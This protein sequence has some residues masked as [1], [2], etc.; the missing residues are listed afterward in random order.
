MYALFSV[1]FYKYFKYLVSAIIFF[2]LL[3][4]TSLS[5]I[6]MMLFVIFN[7]KNSAYVLM[8]KGDTRD[9]YTLDQYEYMSSYFP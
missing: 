1:V 6:P 7:W 8:N 9:A 2:S 4:Y 5:H 3:T